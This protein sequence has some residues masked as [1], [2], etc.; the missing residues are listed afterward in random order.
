MRAGR[1]FIP[2]PPGSLPVIT[3]AEAM[4]FHLNGQ[5]SYVFHVEEAHTDG[6][7]IIHFRNADVIHMGDVFFNGLFPFIDA[8]SGGSLDGYIAAQKQVLALATES[9]QIVP[10]H[11]PMA[12]RDGLAASIAMLEDARKIIG[13]L[14]T[15]GK[16]IDEVI[17]ADPLAAYAEW[18]W[19]FIS[20]EIMIRQVYGALAGDG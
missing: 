14:V 11:G 10:G 17:A 7:A 2:A 15:A 12:T 6:D 16:S 8:D 9:S 3:F 18:D 13:E 20:T 1:E 4:T 19:P 5:E